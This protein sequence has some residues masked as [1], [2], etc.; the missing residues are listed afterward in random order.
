MSSRSL[1]GL[2]AVTP[3]TSDTAALISLVGE[4]VAGGARLVQ[5]RNKVASPELR[6]EHARALLAIC[7]KAHAALI[8]NDDTELAV[9]I[10]ADGL[11]LGRDDGDIAIARARLPSAII[12][13]SCYADVNLA[14]EAKRL[15]VDYVAF[16]S[17]FASSTKPGATRAP[18]SVVQEA[19]RAVDLPIVA[20]GGITLGNAP[21]LIAA[22][23]DAVAVIS[24]LFDAESV[25]ETAGKFEALF[26]RAES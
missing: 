12:G 3:D 8:I 9:K 25:R 1:R 16:G 2:Y 4:A 11:H 5:Y 22:G 15:G 18:L 24:A 23:V 21:E 26:T 20:I 6:L 14:V 17:F 7:R 19:R 10:G 13:A